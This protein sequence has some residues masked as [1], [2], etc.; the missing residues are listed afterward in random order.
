MTGVAGAALVAASSVVVVYAFLGYPALLVAASPFARRAGAPEGPGAG[1]P[2]H[3]TIVVPVHNEE[4]QI[5]D[6]LES[7]LALDYPASRRQILVISDASTDGTD[8]VVREYAGQ[9]VELFRLE[10]R[11]GKTAA[12]NAA[13]P[14]IRGDLVLNTDASVRIEPGAPRKLVAWFA[15][16]GVGVA[17]G[18]DES[19]APGREKDVNAGESGY[20]GYEMW[21]RDLESRL[22]GIV[23][24]SGCLYV[25]RREIQMVPVPEGL[26]RD[27]AA[28][29]VAHELGYRS[30]SVKE[31]VCAVPRAPSLRREYRRKVRTITRGMST[32]LFKRHLL[33]PDA[34]GLF[35]WKLLSHKVARWLVPWAAVTAVVGVGLLAVEHDWARLAL[36]GAGMGVALGAVGWTWPEERP[37]PSVFTIP[38]YLLAGG[39]AVLAA[40]LRAALGRLDP[41]WEPTRRTSAPG[42]ATGRGGD[43]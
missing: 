20:V 31:A 15:D 39:A 27:F 10:K 16:P 37:A 12:E 41:V 34:Q 43:D 26:S 8:A 40:T 23:G 42:T 14:R 25:A 32:L 33:R 5:R 9:G 22:G 30:I 35:A 7:L 13:R 21:V 3:L 36:G 6:T 29:L 1:E 17:S 19:V 24:A 28:A 2:P 11:R 18:R 4:G 38:A